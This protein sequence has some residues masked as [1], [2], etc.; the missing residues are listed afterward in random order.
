MLARKLLTVWR[1]RR[2]TVFVVIGMTA[3]ACGG[4]HGNGSA[5]VTPG[6]TGTPTSAAPAVA[7]FGTLVS[8]CGPGSAR[9]ATA[10]G[11]TNTSIT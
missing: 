3:A 7:K 1:A 10:N 8:P 4:N 5:S 11:V 2:A 9:G 6:S